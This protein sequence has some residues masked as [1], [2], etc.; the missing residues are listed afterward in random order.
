MADWQNLLREVL[1]ADGSIDEEETSLLVQGIMGDGVVD[2]E[3]VDF[4]VDLRARATNLCPAFSNFFFT[5]LKSNF[6]ADGTVDS[7]EARRLREI[8]FADGKVD[9]DEKAFL[10]E[11]K[12]EAKSVSPEFEALFLECMP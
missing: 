8:I 2:D 9:G 10:T 4:L 7:D 5:A 1:L 3:E 11:L 12:T 6:L